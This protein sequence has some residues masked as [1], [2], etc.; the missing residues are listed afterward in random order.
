[1]KTLNRYIS[2]KLIINKNTKYIHSYKYKVTNIGELNSL[3][4]KLYKD[5]GDDANLNEIDVSEV[6]CFATVF[7]GTNFRNID[8]SNWDSKNATSCH[9]MFKGCNNTKTI[10]IS[11]FNTSKI[12]K[13]S[14]MFEGCDK[15]ETIIGL[16]TFDTTN[17]YDFSNVFANCPNLQNIKDIEDWYM[18]KA[19]NLSG[20]FLNC[21]KIDYINLTKWDVSNVTNMQSMFCNSS[22]NG[23]ISTWNV[24]NVKKN[25]FYV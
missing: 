16:N 2:E 25:E 14:M 10:N 21:E 4:V 18:S 17:C 24:E 23:D 19:N 20:M 11:N 5:E 8:I 12:E 6:G 22:F 3:L 7:D 13:L 9:A 1:M 15:L